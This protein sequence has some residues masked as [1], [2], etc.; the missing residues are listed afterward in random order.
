MLWLHCPAGRL[1]GVVRGT[2]LK[3]NKFWQ[4]LAAAG[5]VALITCI[6]PVRAEERDGDLALLRG[7]AEDGDSAAQFTLANHYY[8]GLGVQRDFE[9]ALALYAQAADQGLAAAENLTV[10]P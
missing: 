10:G 1:A 8:R 9:K 5:I 4:G 2:N 6:A 7:A 3:P